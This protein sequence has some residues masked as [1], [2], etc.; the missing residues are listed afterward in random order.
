MWGGLV[1]SCY[2]VSC[3]QRI[4]QTAI[5]CPLLHFG[6]LS[7]VCGY[8]LLWWL[9]RYHETV[10]A[11]PHPKIWWF[12][13]LQVLPVYGFILRG[14]QNAC[15][16]WSEWLLSSFM[17][18][19][20]RVE[21]APF[22]CGYS[23]SWLV[24]PRRRRCRGESPI[25]TPR[26]ITANPPPPVISGVLNAYCYVLAGFYMVLVFFTERCLQNVADKLQ[27]LALLYL[28]LRTYTFYAA[29]ASYLA[30]AL[31]VILDLLVPT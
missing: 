28:P 10:N 21:P 6:P 24:P 5:T 30:W 18:P 26:L 12:L 3:I 29:T 4:A 9:S 2:A 17:V 15:S 1:A 11:V 20:R 8:M 7:G 14:V 19:H 25:W 22:F 16:F 31:S 23:G 13:T 27:K